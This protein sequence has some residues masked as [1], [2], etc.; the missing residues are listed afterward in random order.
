MSGYP[1]GWL[2]PSR[3]RQYSNQPGGLAKPVQEMVRDFTPSDPESDH[4]RATADALRAPEPLEPEMDYDD[5]NQPGE[6]T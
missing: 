3:N 2:V 5:C 6:Q 4:M 1:N